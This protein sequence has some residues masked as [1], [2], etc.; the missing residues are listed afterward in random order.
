MRV[1]HVAKYYPP[2]PG[3]MES[4]VRDLAVATTGMGVDN[5]VL[6]HAHEPGPARVTDQDGVRVVRAPCH[7]SLL[8]APVSPS[9]PLHLSRWSRD[10]RPDLVH[11]HMPNTSAFWSLLPG[12]GKPPLVV[13]WHSDVV[14]SRGHLPHRLALGL[15]S[16]LERSLLRRARRIVATSPDYLDASRPLARFRDRCRVVPLGLD[17]AR[18]GSDP[19]PE[20]DERA[21][22]TRERRLG[23]GPDKGD[24]LVLS[25]GRFAHYKGFPVLARAMAALARRAPGARLVI[26]GDGEER[27]ATA[28]A[29]QEAGVTDRVVLPGH[30][31]DAELAALMRAADLFVLPSLERTEAFGMVL[32]EAMACGCP[33]VTTAIPGSGVNHVNAPGVTGLSVPPSDAGALAEAMADLLTDEP[34]R[35]A[36]GLAARQR[37]EERFSMGAVGRAM[38]GV[39]E[40]ALAQGGSA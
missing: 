22:Q 10:F 30:V 13:H 14:F 1:L 4:F 5:L 25:V 28:R 16:L 12:L 29:A 23:T 11:A 27:R 9:W 40:E 8:Y 2:R 39:Y 31:D 20:P 6:A 37:F 36:M 15:Y 18:L 38:L 35:L 33:L 17:A 21:A 32:L 26:V 19:P 24:M 3:G 34:R 7:G